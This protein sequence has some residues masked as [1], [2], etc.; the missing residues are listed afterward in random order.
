MRRERTGGTQQDGELNTSCVCSCGLP[1]IV[2][3]FCVCARVLCVC[4]SL[5]LSRFFPLSSSVCRFA[6]AVVCV[7]DP[8]A[9]SS[10]AR[11]SISLQP[12][13]SAEPVVTSE[14]ASPRSDVGLGAP[15]SGRA[16]EEK[17]INAH[18]SEAHEV[19][20]RPS[21]A[22]IIDDREEAKDQSH[23]SPATVNVVHDAPDGG[24]GEHALGE[25]YS[26]SDHLI[27]QV[28]ETAS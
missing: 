22:V 10:P 24:H 8:E 3:G 7:A 13:N 4:R 25:H 21:Q 12:L 14:P 17:L 2:I 23:Q 27:V 16:L 11:R 20:R 1:L 18:A 6:H 15:A 5:S 19:E 26:Y 9:L 28:R